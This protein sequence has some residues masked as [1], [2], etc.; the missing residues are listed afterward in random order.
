MTGENVSGVGAPEADAPKRCVHNSDWPCALSGCKG[1]KA[2][3]IQ[4]G[5]H[6][7][8]VL[9]CGKP[10]LSRTSARYILGKAFNRDD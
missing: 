1:P 5:S 8:E 7:E 10:Q 3:I 4:Y 6:Q 9:T 2:A